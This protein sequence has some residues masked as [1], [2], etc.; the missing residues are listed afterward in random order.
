MADQSDNEWKAH[1]IRVAGV[2]VG[3]LGPFLGVVLIGIGT[4]ARMEFATASRLVGIGIAC[5]FSLVPGL[6][7]LALSSRIKE[8]KDRDDEWRRRHGL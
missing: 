1:W 2:I 3:C 5:L 4:G 6:A 7:L 8:S